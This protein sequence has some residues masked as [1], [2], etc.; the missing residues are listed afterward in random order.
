MLVPVT[1]HTRREHRDACAA[2]ARFFERIC[3]LRNTFAGQVVLRRG[4]GERDQCHPSRGHS[5]LTRSTCLTLASES[6]GN[7]AGGIDLVGYDQS[8]GP[9]TVDRQLRAIH[10]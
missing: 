3:K 7:P 4:M 1:R 2:S 8:G 9:A 6:V 10:A 5:S